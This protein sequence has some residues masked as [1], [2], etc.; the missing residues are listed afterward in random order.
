MLNAL[1]PWHPP[2]H[3]T[4][5]QLPTAVMSS[6]PCHWRVLPQFSITFPGLVIR[7]HTFRLGGWKK[8]VWDKGQCVTWKPSW[9]KSPERWARYSFIR[10][11]FNIGSTRGLWVAWSCRCRGKS[12][13][14]TWFIM[15]RLHAANILHACTQKAWLGTRLGLSRTISLL[16]ADSHNLKTKDGAVGKDNVN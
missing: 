6:W 15:A 1:S 11:E 2:A 7:L 3:R 12:G 13:D 16:L 14:Q 4:C 5:Y 10:V 8:R 9:Q